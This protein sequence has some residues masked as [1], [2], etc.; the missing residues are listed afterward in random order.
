MVLFTF[1][2]ELLGYDSSPTEV[3]WFSFRWRHCALLVSMFSASIAQEDRF[4]WN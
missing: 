1:F 3:S 2:K 4:V